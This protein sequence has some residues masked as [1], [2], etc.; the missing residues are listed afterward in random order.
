MD[1]TFATLLKK[2][3]VTRH[4][5]QPAK[6]RTW[7]RHQAELFK[8]RLPALRLQ[9]QRLDPSRDHRPVRLGRR[10]LQVEF[11]LF[12]AALPAARLNRDAIVDDLERL[13]ANHALTTEHHSPQQ[14][15]G[16][17]PR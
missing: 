14:K 15:R 13:A 17:P 6:N 4:N 8:Q 5:S 16:E 2:N 11:S 1:W 7:L 12:R 3:D 10:R 9:P